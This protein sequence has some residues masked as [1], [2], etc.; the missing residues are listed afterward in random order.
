MPGYLLGAYNWSWIE[1]FLVWGGGVRVKL[2]LSEIIEIFSLRGFHFPGLVI[3]TVGSWSIDVGVV[4][5]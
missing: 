1:I 5:D 2:V 3:C 4:W